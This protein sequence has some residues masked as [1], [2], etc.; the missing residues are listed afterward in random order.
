MIRSNW[1]RSALAIAV[2]AALAACSDKPVEPP[3]A[4]APSAATT[5]PEQAAQAPQVQDGVTVKNPWVRAALAEQ[6]ATGAFMT[7]EST[8][9]VTLVGVESPA[10]QVAEVHE[11]KMDGDVMKMRQIES[12]AI[13]PGQPGELKPGSYHIMLMA[14]NG[15]V[16]PGQDL[17]LLLKFKTA[18][19]KAI[20]MPVR[21]QVR[22]V[23]AQGGGHHHH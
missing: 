19:G 13:A 17:E 11:M 6:D 2:C 12:L 21:A 15:P 14:L 5:A 16:T 7:I 18:D 22:D 4:S 23:V 1:T 9:P 10:A 8:Q 20:D 3:A